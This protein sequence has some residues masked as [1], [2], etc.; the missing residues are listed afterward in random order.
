MN[1]HNQKQSLLRLLAGPLIAIGIALAL[2]LGGPAWKAGILEAAMP[3]AVLTIVL[4][5]EYDVEPALVTTGVTMT[6]LLSPL[7]LTPL[8]AF[9]G[10]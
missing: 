9:L 3:S 10:G 4:A 8:L 6:T 5:T 2:G 7:T 1:A